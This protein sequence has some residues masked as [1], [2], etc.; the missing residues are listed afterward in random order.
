[1]TELD[2]LQ[3][4][5]QQNTPTADPSAKSET[6]RLAAEN[7]APSPRKRTRRTSYPRHRPKAVSLEKD[8]YHVQPSN[9]PSRPL[10]HVLPH[11]RGRGVYQLSTVAR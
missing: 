6:L 9:P 8:H 4:H 3:S 2:K 7:F 5:L 10:R 11:R 1:M